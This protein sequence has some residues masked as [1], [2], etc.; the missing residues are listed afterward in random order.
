MVI[1]KVLVGSVRPNRFGPQIAQWLMEL[2]KEHTDATFELVDLEQV[3]LPFLDEPD[4]PSAGNY[5][6]EHTKKWAAVIGP[7]DGFIWV[8]PEY[9]HGVSPA[10]KNAIDYLWKEWNNKPV[11]LAGYGAEAG[12][13]RAAEQLRLVASG[14]MMFDIR[15][16]LV[17]ANYSQ[18]LDESGKFQPTDIQTK[19]AHK[20]LTEIVFW[21]GQFQR[22]RKELSA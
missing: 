6:Q 20:L 5:Q 4:L 12:G 18:Q 8:H 22:A 11:A 17:I 19:I 9:N 2:S 13:S 14:V 7:A 21:S 10:L 16:Q 3:N 1:V 15:T